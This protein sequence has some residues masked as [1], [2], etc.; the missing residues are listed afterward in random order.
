MPCII[1]TTLSACVCELT[2]GG[3]LLKTCWRLGMR[4]LRE[5]CWEG[6]VTTDSGRRPAESSVEATRA[7][8]QARGPS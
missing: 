2:G 7:H 3:F 1:I 8:Q 5:V 6:H 4:H